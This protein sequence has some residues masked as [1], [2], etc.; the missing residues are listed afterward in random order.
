SNM[1]ANEVIAGRANELLAGKRGGKAPVHPNDHVNMGQSSNDSFPSALHVPAADRPPAAVVP[2]LKHLQQAL[3]AK[4]AAFADII[5]IGRTHLQ[6]ATPVTLGQEFSGYAAQMQL[7]VA[8]VE[9]C[10]PRIW[11]LAQ[12]GTAVGTGLNAHPGF[13]L[14][15]AS[16]VARL[17]GLP[18]VSAGNKLEALASHD[19]IIELS[20]AYNVLAASLLKIANDIRLLGSGPRSGLGEVHLPENEPGSSIMP[21]KVNPTQAEAL[22][23]VATQVM[24]NHV[25]VTIAGSQGHF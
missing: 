10:L 3:A 20:G 15:F 16:Q 25:T 19:A 11:P 6:D 7:G 4:A 8:R 22:T 13:A 1:N 24:G 23:M 18:F 5:K 12:G 2:A 14:E 21:G 17:T 9:A